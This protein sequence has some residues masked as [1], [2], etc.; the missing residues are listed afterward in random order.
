MHSERMI[1][2]DPGH[3]DLLVQVLI[4]FAGIEPIFVRPSDFHFPFWLAMY[5]FTTSSETVPTVE[6][7]FERA[8]KLGS[9]LFMNGKSSRMVCAVHP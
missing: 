2:D 9:L 4:P 3:V 1:P 5:A 6:M 8:H 7:N